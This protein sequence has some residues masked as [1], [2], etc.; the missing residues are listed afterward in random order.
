MIA[1]ITPGG[2]A[3]QQWQAKV[4]TFWKPILV[5]G[6]SDDWIGDVATSKPNDN[7]K[8]FH[9]WGQS[10][11]GMSDLVSRLSKPGET[12]CDPFMGAGTTGVVSLALGR[13][14]I[15]CDIDSDHCI[16]SKA[17]LEKTLNELKQ[18]NK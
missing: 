1:Y 14:F 11:S 2:Q 18:C 9:G 12:V 5:F 15:G 4:N 7:D 3:V 8:R 6:K 13:K 16:T 17:R 10:E